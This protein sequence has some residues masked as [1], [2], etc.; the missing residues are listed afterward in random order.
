MQESDDILLKLLQIHYYA[1]EIML[2]VNTPAQAESLLRS[3]EQAAGSIGLCV[4]AN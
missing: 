1:D 4:N 3:L 2:F